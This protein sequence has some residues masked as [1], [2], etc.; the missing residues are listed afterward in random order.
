M[1]MISITLIYL[2]TSTTYYVVLDF[3]YM[4]IP[5][6]THVRV[7]PVYKLKLFYPCNLRALLA[8]KEKQLVLYYRG[9]LR[10]N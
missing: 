8:N 3:I 6:Y 4:Y 9:C 7:A 1:Y 2:L 10:R 5:K